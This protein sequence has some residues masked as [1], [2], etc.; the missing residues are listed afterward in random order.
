[1][2]GIDKGR[3]RVIKAEE[4]RKGSGPPVRVAALVMTALSMLFAC[5]HLAAVL[6][7]GT[8]MEGWTAAVAEHMV[9][10]PLDLFHVDYRILYFAVCIYGLIF[11]AALPKRE[12]PRAEM[13]G[14]EHGSNDFQTEEERD[15]FLA[16]NTSP[17][18]PLE[19][20][21]PEHRRDG[22]E[23]A[24]WIS[25]ARQTFMRPEADV[26]PHRKVW[27]AHLAY[28][29]LGR[30]SGGRTFIVERGRE[31]TDHRRGGGSDGKT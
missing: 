8:R 26:P 29:N 30:L 31:Q 12:L 21:V 27:R 23:D 11:I 7:R 25:D 22:R 2:A 1:M 3:D 24:G 16:G 20:G 17:I 14:I 18:F 6:E 19:L 28:L 9:S 13:K 5:G 10:A 15:L 4:R